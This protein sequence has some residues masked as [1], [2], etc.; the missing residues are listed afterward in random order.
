[1]L[2][3]SFFKKCAALDHVLSIAIPGNKI[4][5]WFEE[6][7]YGNQIALKFPTNA[8]SAMGVAVCCVLQRKRLRGYVQT[9]GPNPK[10]H[11]RFGIDR[12]LIREPEAD[13]INASATTEN[14]SLWIVYIPFELFQ[15][16]MY[17]DIQGKRWSLFVEGNLIIS[18][19]EP[20]DGCEKILRCGA[21]LIFEED[22]ES[23]QQ[24]KTDVCDYRNSFLLCNPDLENSFTLLEM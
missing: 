18:I 14:K 10:I 15:M 20:W 11:L 3:Q 17:D 6:Q 16:K 13:Y 19:L 7:R 2:H 8:H 5:S 12:S 1:M 21:R 4:P 22:V 23:V 9:I 24:I